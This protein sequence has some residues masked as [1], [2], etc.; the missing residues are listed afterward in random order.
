MAPLSNPYRWYGLLSY[1]GCFRSR[2]AL[3][4]PLPLLPIARHA[5]RSRGIS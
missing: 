4:C 3:S 1:T 2:P 5:A